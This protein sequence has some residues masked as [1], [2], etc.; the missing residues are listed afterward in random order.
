MTKAKTIAFTGHRSL[1]DPQ[2]D[3]ILK[4][5]PNVLE[6]AIKKGYNRFI[7]GGALGF[8]QIAA[9]T[10]I[11][12]KDNCDLTLWIAEPFYGFTDKWTEAQ[13]AR[14]QTV[15]DKANQSFVISRDY[16]QGV[17]QIRNEWMVDHSEIVVA[18]WN[19]QPSGTANTVEYAIA[20]GK[21][22]CHL[23]LTNLSEKWLP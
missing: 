11:H 15:R 2:C 4:T 6:R 7:S 16:S 12:L 14:Y 21:R 8:D 5:L 19:G 17:Y 18:A 1:T 13:K 23:N 20:E 9:E 3:W 10:V 22:V